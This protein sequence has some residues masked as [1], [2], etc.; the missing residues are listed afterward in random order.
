MKKRIE[1]VCSVA[2]LATLFEHKT[3]ITGVLDQTV[4]LIAQHMGAEVCSIYLLETG[5]RK[6]CLRATVGLDA[7]FIGKV[8]LM[9]GEGITGTALREMRPIIVP[10][11]SESPFNKP[12]PGI[13]EENYEAFLAVP[14]I[15]QMKR[16]GVITLQHSKQ[17][18]FDKRDSQA[19]TA[20]AS[21]L[22]TF[23]ENAKLLME[24]HAGETGSEDKKNGDTLPEFIKG[25]T[26]SEGIAI[27]T[28]HLFTDRGGDH[29]SHV[30][31]KH[32]RQGIE[33][34]HYALE[35]T[36]KQIELLQRGVEE[37]LSDV[38]GLIFSSHLLMLTDEAF[39]GEMEK[40][41]ENGIENHIAVS[42]VVNMYIG[43]LKGSENEIV[44]EKVQDLKDLG[45]RILENLLPQDEAEY[46]YTGHIIV[47][48]EVFPSELVRLVAQNAEGLILQ[49]QGATSHIL[50]L[51]KS[52][53]LP[54]ITVDSNTLFSV[55]TRT[56][57]VID[58]FQG[59]V[60][61][62][63]RQE[64]LSHY[65][66]YLTTKN[67]AIIEGET[68]HETTHLKSGEE[69][70]LYANVSLL[71]DVHLALRYKAKGVGLYRSEFPFLIRNSFPSEEEQCRIYSKL[72]SSAGALPVVMRI[73]D[74]GG[75]K[76]LTHED[77]LEEANPF[78]GLRGIRF[79][80]KNREILITQ[81][82]AMLQAGI[83]DGETFPVFILIPFI[84]SLDELLEV[85][86]I[87]SKCISDLESEGVPCQKNPQLGIMVELPSTIL[88][89][90][91]LAEAAD[92]I[93]IGTNDLVQYVIGVDRTNYMVSDYYAPLHPAVIRSVKQV[94]DAGKKAGIPVSICGESA[95]DPILAQLYIGMGI[96][97]LSVAPKS[98]PKLQRSIER[99][100][101]EEARNFAAKAL[102]V[103]TL[104]E[105]REIL[106]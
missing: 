46:D 28:V 50:I 69:I 74:L 102:K 6:L 44:A 101:M 58:A 42:S 41:I 99:F 73:L 5:T 48:K 52:L 45:H 98:I 24:L 66:H 34:F 56:P 2:E 89:I 43:L 17:G 38:G 77:A 60:F 83:Q 23:I 19:M 87:V 22:A 16:I 63:P 1:L 32:Y 8:F 40:H 31:G 11:L 21:Q 35:K 103:S 79:T 97:R 106:L 61:I 30:P 47:S 55:P 59:T 36:K 37:N 26:R 49:N 92:F 72:L 90:D 105:L 62:N 9:M 80:L 100:S 27:G 7:D 18:F 54:I 25:D 70:S 29:L 94:I 78:L 76:K 86:S 88:I 51:A 82:R 67:Q 65:Q 91:E 104:K 39:S 84:S 75:D 81:V 12:V 33:A 13:G 85:R 95:A 4:K 64:V 53:N 3:S 57:I 68:T 15:Y 71:S 96:D 20:I 14:L 10:S 93:S